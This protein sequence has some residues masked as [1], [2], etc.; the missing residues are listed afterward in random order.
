LVSSFQTF[1]VGHTQDVAPTTLSPAVRRRRSSAGPPLAHGTTGGFCRQFTQAVEL[2][3][4]RWTGAILRALIDG[5]RRFHELTEIVPGL[6]ERLL[7]ERLKELERE[8]VVSRT[9]RPGPPVAVEY[10]LTESGRDLGEAITAIG[11]WAHRWLPPDR[12]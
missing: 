9:V 11:A 8:G 5:P 12:R 2:I 6:S 3:G 1:G 7:S 4:R 10:E